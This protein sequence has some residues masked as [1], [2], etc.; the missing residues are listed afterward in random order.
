[1]SKLGLVAVIAGG[2]VAGGLGLAGPAAATEAL[3]PTDL[4][5]VPAGVDH[6]NWLDQVHHGATAPSVDTSVRH[7]R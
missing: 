5:V 4:V 3:R 1:M 7:S 2:L 6:L